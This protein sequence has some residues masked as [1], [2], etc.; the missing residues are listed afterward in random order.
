MDHGGEGICAL[1]CDE[2]RLKWG[3][4]PAAVLSAR[5]IE[6]PLR[7]SHGETSAEIAVAFGLSRHTV[8]RHIGG[9]CAKFNVETRAQVGDRA[10]ANSAAS[11]ILRNFIS[12]GRRTR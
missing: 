11:K 2:P 5:Q 9:A 12:A 4:Q 1:K 10:A 8:D 7:I 3:S 6:C